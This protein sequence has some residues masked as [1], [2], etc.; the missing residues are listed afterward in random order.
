[1]IRILKVDEYNEEYVV[2]INR[3]LKQLSSEKISFQKQELLNIINSDSSSLYLMYL[4][5]EII[6]M[7]TLCACL[8]PT[9]IKY[10]L[11]DVVLD[12]KYRGQSLGKELVKAAIERV[13]L[14]GKSKLMLTSRPE[15]LIANSL[16]KS[17]GFK[18]RNT[19]VYRMDFN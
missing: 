15:R 14:R 5:D 3:L 19:N 9:G 7:F 12:E 16:Y 13:S 11:E 1:M 2:A 4:K 8:A 10:W 18:P 6:G 17:L